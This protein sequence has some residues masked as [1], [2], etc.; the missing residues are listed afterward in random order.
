M[1]SLVLEEEE[2][3]AATKKTRWSAQI[4]VFQK[5]GIDVT[6]RPDGSPLVNRIHFN[7]MTGVNDDNIKDKQT[8]TLNLS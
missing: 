1:N 3:K 4:T 8:V 6:A 5:M 2:I 7:R